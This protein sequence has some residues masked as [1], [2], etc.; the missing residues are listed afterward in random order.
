[1]YA[2]LVLRVQAV[3]ECY[4]IFG[5][6]DTLEAYMHWRGTFGSFGLLFSFSCQSG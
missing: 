6:F 5:V 2:F 4:G 1:M 3:C